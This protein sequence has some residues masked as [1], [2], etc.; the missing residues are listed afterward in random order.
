MRRREFIAG[1]GGVAAWPV[2][3]R[4]QQ[5]ERMRRIGVLLPAVADDAE[6]QA[7]LEAFLQGLALP[8]WTIGRNVRI[9][10]R[11][12]GVNEGLCHCA[13]SAT[14]NISCNRGAR[15]ARPRTG[16]DDRMTAYLVLSSIAEPGGPAG[17]RLR[18]S[19]ITAPNC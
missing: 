9:D 5:P 11:W 15:S 18:L 2:M 10:T 14:R 3:A 16:G 8:G 12:A 17:D 13:R 19:A 4:A 1:L 6:F 7:R